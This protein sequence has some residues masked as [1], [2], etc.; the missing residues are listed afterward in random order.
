MGL[1]EFDC[2]LEKRMAL[3]AASTYFLRNLRSKSVFWLVP[4]VC[5]WF[6]IVVFAMR[7]EQDI[8]LVGFAMFFLIVSVGYAPLFWYLHR[9]AAVASVLRAP[10]LHCCVSKD[11]LS[12]SSALGA[13]SIS[14]G[15]IRAVW[16][17]DDFII[18]VA[19]RFSYL[20]LPS[21]Q[22]PEAGKMLIR[23]AGKKLKGLVH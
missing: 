15:D 20:W 18:L 9:Q 22:I 17:Y 3:A 10:E 4:S 12:V 5:I 1:V 8:V 13:A 21:S 16:E 7:G 14:L 2:S 19:G 6:A 11:K 23:T